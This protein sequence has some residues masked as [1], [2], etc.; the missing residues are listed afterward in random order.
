MQEL[1]MGD[2]ANQVVHAQC[3]EFIFYQIAAKV[4]LI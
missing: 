2:L 4:V 3:G 1:S